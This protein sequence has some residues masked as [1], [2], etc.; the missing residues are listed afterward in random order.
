MDE[1]FLNYFFNELFYFYDLL[2]INGHIIC[3]HD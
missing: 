2:L 3:L 1:G